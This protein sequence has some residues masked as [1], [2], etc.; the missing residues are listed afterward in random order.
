MTILSGTLLIVFSAATIIAGIGLSVAL[1]M[2]ADRAR[3]SEA[4]RPEPRLSR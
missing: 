2:G 1:Y 3:V 4:N